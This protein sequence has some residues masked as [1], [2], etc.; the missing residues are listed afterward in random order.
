MFVVAVAVIVNKVVTTAL[1]AAATFGVSYAT[2]LRY[3]CCWLLLSCHVIGWLLLFWI[4]F[5]FLFCHCSFFDDA[6][7]ALLPMIRSATAF[8]DTIT[9][10]LLTAP[11]CHH[12]CWLLLL[13]SPLPPV[14]CCFCLCCCGCCCFLL[15][16]SL[17][18]ACDDST[19]WLS[20]PFPCTIVLL[21]PLPL[22]LVV[23]STIVA[24]C[25]LIVASFLWSFHTC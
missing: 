12:Y 7:T 3:C 25:Q 24:G 5:W 8:A 11:W 2:I 9:P 16:R 17:P 21:T 10:F 18:L 14:D 1:A 4:I 6:A 13:P 23:I 19:A 20:P 15:L 22:L